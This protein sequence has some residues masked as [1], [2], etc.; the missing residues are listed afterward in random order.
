MSRERSVARETRGGMTNTGQ[1][2]E[3]AHFACYGAPVADFRLLGTRPGAFFRQLELRR[4]LACAQ[5][6]R[7][8]NR[9]CERSVGSTRCLSLVTVSRGGVARLVQ[10][11]A[12]RATRASATI[13]LIGSTYNAHRQRQ[14]HKRRW[15]VVEGDS[16]GK[17]FRD[18]AFRRRNAHRAQSSATGSGAARPDDCTLVDSLRQ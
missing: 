11:T 4:S 2:N 1:C 7:A 10:P 18:Q 15:I 8:S 6:Q 14:P 16:N 12:T 17:R 13:A 9:I 3:N 5:H